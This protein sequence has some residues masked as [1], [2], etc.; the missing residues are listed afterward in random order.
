MLNQL[1]HDLWIVVFVV[2]IFIGVFAAQSLVIGFGVMGLLLAGTAW[3]WNRL[4]LQELTY[5]RE[6]SQ[7]RVFI[8]EEFTMSMTL[9]NRK[10]IP[11]GRVQI[12]DDI[13]ESVEFLDSET[14]LS[15]LPET[16]TLRIMSRPL[17]PRLH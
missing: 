10:P 9:T 14:V 5:E 17:P 2:L 3:I 7:Q 16:V 1:W 13:P 4:A 12:E 15:P 6:L 11:L 8:G